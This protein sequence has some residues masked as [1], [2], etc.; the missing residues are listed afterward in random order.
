L[1]IL[2]EISP[3]PEE[4][5]LFKD[6]SGDASL[7][8]LTDFYFYKIRFIPEISDRLKLWQY[9]KTFHSNSEKILKVMESN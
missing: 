2:I 1:Q 3:T 7:L 9:R 6:F 4:V 5:Q 8:S